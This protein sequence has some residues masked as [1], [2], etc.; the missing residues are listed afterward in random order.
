[1]KSK[2]GNTLLGKE[3]FETKDKS[4]PAKNHNTAFTG[5]VL[6]T[7]I[8]MVSTAE[9]F[10]PDL[11]EEVLKQRI[12]ECASLC[13][14]GPHALA[15]LLDPSDFGEEQSQRMA[16]ILNY[17]SEE[18]FN[19]S[20]VFFYKE[21]KLENVET[22]KIL[23]SCGGR[24]HQYK[25]RNQLEALEA[26]GEMVVK[27]D[28]SFVTCTIYDDATEMT[29]ADISESTRQVERKGF[30]LS[31]SGSFVFP[32]KLSL[33]LC[34]SDAAL[35]SSAA[36]LILGLEEPTELSPL[37]SSACVKRDAL[38]YGQIITLVILPPLGKTQLSE[39]VALRETVQCLTLCGSRVHAFLMVVQCPLSEEDKE[40][41]RSILH[42]FGEEAESHCQIV[43]MGEAEHFPQNMADIMT[44]TQD[45]IGIPERSYHNLRHGSEA[46]Q[47]LEQVGRTG[48]ENGNVF[49]TLDMYVAAQIRNQLK[50]LNELMEMRIN[51]ET[52]E[53]KDLQQ[54]NQDHIP[55]APDLNLVLCGSDA[56]LKSYVTDLI[57]GLDQQA[58]PSPQ[59]S[60]ACVKRE[61]AVCGRHV[62]LVLLPSLFDTQLAEGEIIQEV[63]HILHHNDPGVHAFLLVMP[64][65][66]PSDDE[67]EELKRIQHFFGEEV[68]AYCQQVITE[69][70]V[71][72]AERGDGSCVVL[73]ADG[74]FQDQY[75]LLD[76]SSKVL[77]LLE[78]VE[79]MIDK[80]AGCYTANTFISAQLNSLL[81]CHQQL[82]ELKMT[83]QKFEFEDSKEKGPDQGNTDDLRI[84]LLGKTGNGKS[85]TGN[86]ILG[87]ERFN[88]MASTTSVTTECR[89]ET[90]VI[91]G[92]PITVVDTPGFFDT[93]YDNDASKREIIRCI[94]MAAPG[95]HAFLLVFTS[96]GRFTEEEKQTVQMIQ[97]M[98]GEE[99][100]KYMLVL[101][102]RGDDLRNQSFDDYIQGA[103][104]NL[105]SFLRQCGQRYHL[106]NNRD[107]SNKDQVLRLLDK[108]DAMLRANGGQHY[109]TEMFQ[110]AEDALKQ[111]QERI[112]QEREEQIQKE[113]EELLMKHKAE[114]N[115]LKREM[116]EERRRQE[117]ER[118]MREEEFKCKEE[119]MKGAMKTLEEEERCKRSK[120]EED[121]KL[122]KKQ[123]E[124]WIKKWT[125][126][127]QLERQR[128]QEEWERKTHAEQER[129]EEE[130]KQRKIK[131]TEYEQ[132]WREIQ[133]K[134][135]DIFNMEREKILKRAEEE[136][137]QRLQEYED[138]V[139]KQEKKREDLEE[140]I[141]HAEESRVK[142]LEEQKR[143]YEEECQRKDEEENKRRQEEENRWKQ[144]IELVEKEWS[145]K[146]EQHRQERERYE[147]EQEEEKK[148]REAEEKLK[149]LLDENERKT[150]EHD[151]E[152][153]I[154]EK[155]LE[156]KKLQ[157]YYAFQLM[158]EE[159][160]SRERE[161]QQKADVEEKFRVQREQ[162]EKQKEKEARD[163]EER[164]RRNIEYLKDMY[165][166]EKDLLRRETEME[167]RK[168]AEKEFHE[169]L[170]R[171]V[172]EAKTKGHDEGYRQGHKE[173]YDK[174][175]ED[176]EKEG[177]VKGREEG[178]K[179]GHVKGK[180][181]G[182]KKGHAVGYMEG[183]EEFEAEQSAL[184]RWIDGAINSFYN[185]ES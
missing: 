30:S 7:Y 55:S 45:I 130:E 109:T 120:M 67:N 61:A 66:V 74:S 134:Q 176:G 54:S 96:T 173:G 59:P 82:E 37:P 38:V 41:I 9:L 101:F 104:P 125:E 137:R 163:S 113:K 182:F 5:Y 43:F 87:S 156:M 122:Q 6:N 84:V 174:G 46:A 162:F 36:D 33:V 85:A 102:T 121:F 106:F 183:K 112:L 94:A 80:N 83:I 88:A 175:R 27:N 63:Q 136:K 57:L 29:E 93:A 140:K 110:N 26:I 107:E 53:N 51:V 75:Y 22:E 100:E 131:E 146:Q 12:K 40:E 178:K 180:E 164:E 98:F 138:R 151:A 1:M 24:K 116:E 169:I 90:A 111:N 118:R 81:K 144:Q 95:P 71:L 8:T 117:E 133:K 92:R 152:R 16:Q 97:Q 62:T 139:N 103:D 147:R 166:K 167:A 126:E 64:Q 154:K 77:P 25:N 119:E 79:R 31:S 10:T 56:V 39:D 14:P 76:H 170:D 165:E 132:F 52:L 171:K 149:K 44:E 179:E 91:N 69:E 128:Q 58:E 50:Y 124:E 28:W 73:N 150:I 35:K 11:S 105:K 78:K 129:K 17:F 108:I 181:E 23:A 135:T 20:I 160:R 2:V 13:A 158:D 177:Y 159:K 161:A 185:D 148:K 3:V 157:Q 65:A 145:I 89:K 68:D 155:E 32:Q 49:Y 115:H 70:S 99:S 142:D 21:T 47:F 123:N 15:L 114:M 34:G 141:K 153:K 42:F 48:E 184:G 72:C 127:V 19:H 4:S 168:Q 18:V 60:S 143:K 172:K 86:T